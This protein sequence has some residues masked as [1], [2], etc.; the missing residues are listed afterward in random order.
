MTNGV[1][2]YE[3]VTPWSE[4]VAEQIPCDLDIK[5]NPDILMEV[6][7]VSVS[8]KTRVV[9]LGITLTMNGTT[10]SFSPSDSKS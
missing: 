10:F 4:F 6:T 1:G 3:E 8:N 7:Y 2:N 9:H 5:F